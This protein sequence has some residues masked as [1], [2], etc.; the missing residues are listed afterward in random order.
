MP[1]PSREG[2]ILDSK[3]RILRRLGEGGMGA[4][5]AGENIRVKRTVAIKILHASASQVDEMADRFEREAQAAGEIGNEHIVEVYDLGLTPG[6][7]RYM[8]MEYLD[9]ES[10]RARIRRN[11]RLQPAEVAR[12]MV[13]MLDGLEAAHRAGIIHRDLK[14]DNI[15]ILT[16]KAGRK[17]FVKILDFGISKF[18]QAGGGSATQTGT[19][20]GSPNY[21]SPEHIRSSHEV[22][23]RS[24]VYAVGVM[25]YEAVVGVVPRKAANFAELLFK[26]A[27]EPLPDPRVVVPD[28]PAEFVAI[29][30]RACAT[31]RA[32]RFQSARELSDALGEFLRST[33]GWAP[34]MLAPAPGAEVPP[35]SGDLATIALGHGT[36]HPL[37]PPSAQIPLA[38]PSQPSFSTSQPSYNRTGPHLPQPGATSQPA[39]GGAQPPLAGPSQAGYAQPALSTSQPSFSQPSFSGSQ[40]SFSQPSFSGSQPSFGPSSQPSFNQNPAPPAPPSFGATS[41]PSYTA[42][43]IAVAAQAPVHAGPSTRSWTTMIIA[44]AALAGIAIASIIFATTQRTPAA[45]STRPSDEPTNVASTSTAASSV[46]AQ[47]PASTSATATTAASEEPLS[48]ASAAKNPS[49]QA[50]QRVPTARQKPEAGY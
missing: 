47:A 43:P 48:S 16:E 38:P 21:M 46:V 17:D 22:D 50:T 4:V 10:L 29:I 30:E 2:E 14:P 27:Y 9:G 42:G 15:Y 49:A 39:F 41:Q 1:A 12:L 32:A 31:D 35:P 23:V 6:G 33:L 40:P 44:M 20:M 36:P 3:Y 13:D 37:L 34:G 7:E 45:A 19:V 11:K 18:T 24:D 26:V 25:L 28:L 8:V 5:Y